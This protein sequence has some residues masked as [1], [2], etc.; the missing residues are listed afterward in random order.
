MD[1]AEQLLAVGI[2]LQVLGDL[3]AE[4]DTGARIDRQH[5]ADIA[6][7]RPQ[8]DEPAM[9]FRLSGTAIGQNLGGIPDGPVDGAQQRRGKPLDDRIIDIGEAVGD[10]LRRSQDI[11][12]V[13]IDLRHGKAE[14]GEVLLLLQR[15]LQLLLHG[16]QM[17]PGDREFVAP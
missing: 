13:V 11:A 4:L 10:Q 8:L 1:D 15:F 7:Q 14:I 2:D 9:R 12:H 16:R 5:F 3:N 17:L 6:H